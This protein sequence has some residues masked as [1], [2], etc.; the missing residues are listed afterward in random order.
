M[1]SN[2]SSVFDYAVLMFVFWTRTLRCQMAELLFEKQPLGT[3]LRC[4]GGIRVDRNGHDFAFVARSEEILRRGGVVEIFPESRLPRPGEERPLPFKPSAAYLALASG[5]PLIPVFTNGS[6]FRRQRAVVVI[7]RPLDPR[8]FRS[9]E[10]SEKKAIDALSK[11]MRE[12]I[13]ELEKEYQT[14]YEA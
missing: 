8:T 4:L 12:R 1:F 5:V 9:G 11:A 6:Y 3:L 2:H 13:I 7:G 10:R 14:R